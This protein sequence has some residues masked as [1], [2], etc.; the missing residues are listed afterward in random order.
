MLKKAVIVAGA[1]AGLLA[2]APVAN[3]DS[4][5]NDGVNILN[6]NFDLDMR[7]QDYS[8]HAV[9]AGA[10]VEAAAYVEVMIGDRVMWGAGMHPNIAKASLK[11][12]ISAVNRYL[13]DNS[14]D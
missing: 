12:V 2:L 1:A 4:S 9:G 3:A 8:E 14:D 10:D 6:D 5:D 7:V 11:A 13:R